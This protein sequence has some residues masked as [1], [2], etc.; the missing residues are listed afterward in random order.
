MLQGLYKVELQTVHMDRA[1]GGG[2]SAKPA[3]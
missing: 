3:R 1:A 2:I